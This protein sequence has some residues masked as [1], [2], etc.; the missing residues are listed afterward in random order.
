MILYAIHNQHNNI[1]L[2]RTSLL[3]ATQN[4]NQRVQIA[5]QL[6]LLI[7]ILIRD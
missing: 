3:V 4:K 7:M 6:P 5:H 1:T 2:L